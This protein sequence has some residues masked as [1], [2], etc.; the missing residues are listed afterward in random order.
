MT[1]NELPP[2]EILRT[3]TEMRSACARS[4]TLIGR[5]LLISIQESAVTLAYR[6]P[7]VTPDEAAVTLNGYN[8]TVARCR[9]VLLSA[10][11]HEVAAGVQREHE[12]A[13]RPIFRRAAGGP[14]DVT[15][16]EQLV[17]C[18]AQLRGEIEQ[19][20]VRWLRRAGTAR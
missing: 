14:R 4:R 2:E 16:T 10:D 11:G 1:V 5:G 20:R 17:G 15:F 9:E 19:L 8:E 18:R 13:L 12:L 6:N 7:A 3:V